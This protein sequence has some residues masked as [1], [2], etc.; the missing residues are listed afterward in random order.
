MRKLW[1]PFFIISALHL[2]IIFSVKQLSKKMPDTIPSVLAVFPVG[3]FLLYC[4]SHGKKGFRAIMAHSKYT[5]WFPFWFSYRPHPVRKKRVDIDTIKKDLQP[6]DI[7]LRRYSR[8]IDEFVFSE[9]S[10]FTH[11]GIYVDDYNGA[12]SQI[13]HCTSQRNVHA[14]SLDDFCNGDDIAVL[15]FSFSVSPEEEK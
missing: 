4:V 14:T 3:C 8:Y 7:F 6:G 13:L 11:A 1:L 15:R 12:T 9:N 5:L 10:F 2:T